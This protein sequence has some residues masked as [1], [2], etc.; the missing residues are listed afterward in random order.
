M[1]GAFARERF[2][3]FPGPRFFRS[4]GALTRPESYPRACA[5]GFILAPLRGW[6]QDR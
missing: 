1:Q 5:L 2:G 3:R 4:F 6:A